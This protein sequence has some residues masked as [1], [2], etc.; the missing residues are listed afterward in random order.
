MI[1]GGQTEARASTIIDYHAPFDQGFN[2]TTAFKLYITAMINHV[3]IS[4]SAVQYAEE[5][6]NEKKADTYCQKHYT[7]Q[8]H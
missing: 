8:I 5:K 2:F 1:V 3:F 7:N 4:F 6:S